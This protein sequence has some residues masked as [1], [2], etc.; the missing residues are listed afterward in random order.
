[1]NTG[2]GAFVDCAVTATTP[3]AK[4]ASPESCRANFTAEIIRFG[5]APGKNQLRHLTERGCGTDQNTLKIDN[6]ILQ[7]DGAGKAAVNAPQPKR[8]RAVRGSRLSRQ[9]LDC[10]GFST[11][12]GLRVN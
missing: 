3:L 10:G 2:A 12:F 7:F 4:T 1:V 11:A 9:R 8:C 6:N 5:F